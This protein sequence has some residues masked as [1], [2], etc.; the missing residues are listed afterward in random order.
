MPEETYVLLQSSKGFDGWR[1]LFGHAAPGL[2]VVPPDSAPGVLERVR[3]ACVWDP[4]EGLFAA[5]PNLRAVLALG[6]GVDS[7]I[8]DPSLPHQVV[9]GRI[10]DPQM[11]RMVTEYAVMAVLWH[12]RG[13]GQVTRN[14]ARQTWAKP[15]QGGRRVG[16]LGLGV[17]GRAVAQALTHLGFDVAG[18]SLHPKRL[19]PVE[20]F[21]GSP[22]LA[23]FLA[24]SETLINLLPLTPATRS[25]LD[26]SLLSMLPR[27]ACLVNMGRGEHLVEADLLDALDTGHLGGA[28]LDV[29]RQEPLPESSPLWRHPRVLVTPHMAGASSREERARLILAEI[30]RLEQGLAPTYPADRARG[31]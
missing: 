25:I 21:A 1:G 13:F 12:H 29:F 3:Y 10:V 17:L 22:C 11:T 24:R 26:R 5:L 31:Y 7:F 2:R 8:G 30:D 14:Q 20:T 18:Y 15:V 19:P 16:V 4:P 27:G 9:I 6:A 23:S 28:V